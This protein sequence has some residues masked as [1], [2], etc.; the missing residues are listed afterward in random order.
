MDFQDVG[1]PVFLS[2]PASDA[3]LEERFEPHQQWA[4]G[5]QAAG[6]EKLAW[7]RLWLNAYS[8]IHIAGIY[9]WIHPRLSILE[10]KQKTYQQQEISPY[11]VDHDII[12]DPI[13]HNRHLQIVC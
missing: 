6:S 4:T 5:S 13:R 11:S 3:P 10:T 12:L 1:C 7:R 2:L 9:P 8:R